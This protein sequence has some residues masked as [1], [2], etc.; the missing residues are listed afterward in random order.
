M[1]IKD[2]L[3]RKSLKQSLENVKHD[4][5]LTTI[6]GAKGLE[7]DYVIMPDLEKYSFPL[8][9]TCKECGFN[10]TCSI[11][12]NETSEDFKEKYLEELNVF[13]T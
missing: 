4:V 9:Y 2:S 5:I 3:E 13:F 11:N 7:W 6:H 1:I 10:Q 8:Y 12:W